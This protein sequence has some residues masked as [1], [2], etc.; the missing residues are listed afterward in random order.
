MLTK[1]RFVEVV[2][3]GACSV[4][5]MGNSVSEDI[6]SS[7]SVIK[8]L[9]DEPVC[10]IMNNT[11]SKCIYTYVNAEFYKGRIIKFNYFCR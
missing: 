11:T 6:V 9:P 10:T 2:V 8:L 1:D 3:T 7:F 5:L 4:G